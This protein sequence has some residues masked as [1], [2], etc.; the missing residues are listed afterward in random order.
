MLPQSVLAWLLLIIACAFF[1]S[2]D[3][4]WL[5][6]LGTSVRLACGRCLSINSTKAVA[7]GS[8]L[9]SDAHAHQSWFT[10]AALRWP[11][12]TFRAGCPVCGYSTAAIGQAA[13]AISA[14]GAA[15]FLAIGR[16]M[17]VRIVFATASGFS[18]EGAT[19]A[20]VTLR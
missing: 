18:V 2:V 20:V 9:S 1:D 8:D 3:C 12:A 17:P 15:L 19:E 6:P 14:R 16:Q 13:V 4:R 5:R 10:E 7:E 11:R